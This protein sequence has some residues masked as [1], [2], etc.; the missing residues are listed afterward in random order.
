MK[1]SSVGRPINTVRLSQIGRR[2][3]FTLKIFTADHS[4]EH[5]SLASVDHRPTIGRQ[6]GD[7]FGGGRPSTDDRTTGHRQIFILCT[8]L[9]HKYVGILYCCVI[10]H[11]IL[12]CLCPLHFIICHGRGVVCHATKSDL[13]H[14][15]LL[16]S[17]VENMASIWSRLS[18][19]SLS[20]ALLCW[21]YNSIR[22]DNSVNSLCIHMISCCRLIRLISHFL[23]INR[24][25]NYTRNI[26][27]TVV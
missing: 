12:R 3:A 4:W 22:F 9:L 13:Y 17:L 25:Q 10:T 26:L 19:M 1:I 7:I 27:C 15:L 21:V 16:C 24:I 11:D 6:S 5:F 14:S 2:L 23:F 18:S 8:C 20:M